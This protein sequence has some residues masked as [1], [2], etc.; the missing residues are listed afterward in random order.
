MPIQMQIFSLNAFCKIIL[1]II[2]LHH[3]CRQWATA[4]YSMERVGKMYEEYFQRVYRLYDRGWY[5]PN[6]ERSELNWLERYYPDV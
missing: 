5:Q 3:P 6:D 2:L 4:N 1:Q